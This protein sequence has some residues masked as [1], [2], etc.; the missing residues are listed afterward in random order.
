MDRSAATTQQLYRVSD[1]MRLLSLSRSV[2]YEQIRIGRL[3][4][5]TQGRTRLIPA[6]AIAD[7]I[8]LL[9][10]EADDRTA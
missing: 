7:Y 3:K 4:S 8:A 5:V 2:I 10:R 9:Q 1:A 6:V